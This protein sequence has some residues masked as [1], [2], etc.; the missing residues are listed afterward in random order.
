MASKIKRFADD[1]WAIW[2]NG[3]DTSTIYMNDW[4]NPNGKNY[5]DIA[6][7]IRGIMDSTALNIFIPFLI[8]ADEVEDVSLKLCDEA[9]LRATF[10]AI[11]IIDFKKNAYTSEIAYKG[12]TID[13]VH[14]SSVGFTMQT[15]QHSSLMKVDFSVLHNYLDNDEAYILF[16]IPHKSLDE[17][18]KPILNVDSIFEKM[19]DLLTTPVIEER[20]GYSIRINEERLLPSE[21]YRIGAFHRQKL[22]K[23][24]ITLSVSENYELNDANCYRIRRLEEDLYKSYVPEGFSCEDVI[25]YQWNQTREQNL[26]GHFNFYFDISHAAIS[27]ASVMIYMIILVIVGSAGSAL[28]DLLKYIL[29]AML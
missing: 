15:F 18:F 26:Q 27:K 12:R 20:Y 6:V 14:L 4:I 22:K 24:V 10:S 11:C 3:D 19:R 1:G 28:Y 16:R 7:R 17:T 9:I 21:I 23:A 8:T 25:T 2:I 5:I 13:L 29:M